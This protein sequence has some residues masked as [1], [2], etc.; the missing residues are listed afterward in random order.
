MGKLRTT[1]SWTK[2]GRKKEAEDLH[3][4]SHIKNL[5]YDERVDLLVGLGLLFTMQKK[6]DRGLSSPI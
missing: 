6:C 2:R 3:P 1:A 4:P 5:T